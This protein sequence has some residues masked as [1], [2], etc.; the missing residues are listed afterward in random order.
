MKII[1]HL[2]DGKPL[3]GTSPNIGG[4]LSKPSLI[5]DHY[6]A[7]DGSGK[8]SAK[9]LC[10][11]AAKASAHVVIADDGSLYQIV[12]FNRKAW[13]AGK[14]VW[15]GVA[16]CNDFSIGLEVDNW[17][18]LTKREDGTFR[19]HRDVAIPA[20]DVIHRVNKRG[21]DGYWQAYNPKQLDVLEELH[22]ALLE[23]YPSIK[24]VVGHEDIAPARK[25]DPGPAFPLERYNNLVGG[26]V[27][28]PK[29]KR[30]VIATSLNV[31]NGPGREFSVVGS[32]TQ[33]QEVTVVYDGGEWSQIQSG[34][35]V[36]W[37]FDAML[38]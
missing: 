34:Q 10:N 23:A 21:I 3:Y 2:I 30:K 38:S 26:R 31:R 5:V 1:N 7:G 11:P 9:F 28:A 29:L 37:V 15:R 16:N 6:T 17:G 32:L 13:H 4:T 20:K 19:S 27:N 24:E 36:G 25:I 22:I 12:P 33:G 35:T 8:G 14:S 18:L